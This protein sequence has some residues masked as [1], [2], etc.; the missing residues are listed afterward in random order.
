MLLSKGANDNLEQRIQE[1]LEYL[2]N[3]NTGLATFDETLVRRMIEEVNIFDGNIT[4]R[5][6]SG[7]EVKL[8]F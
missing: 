5:L 2:D 8:G 6:K 7:F 3:Q 1:M 4:I